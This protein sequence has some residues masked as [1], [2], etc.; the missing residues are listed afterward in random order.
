MGLSIHT[1]PIDWTSG[2]VPADWLTGRNSYR[3]SMFTEKIN[4]IVND[5]EHFFD[6]QDFVIRTSQ[7]IAQPHQ[8]LINTNNG[9]RFAHVFPTNQSWELYFPTAQKIIQRRATR[10]LEYMNNAKKILVVWASRISGSR[11][12]FFTPITDQEIKDAVKKMSKKFPNADI[13]F[14]FFEHD[15]TKQQFEYDKREIC[16]GAYRIFSNHFILTDDYVY[17]HP[18]SKNCIPFVMCEMLDNISTKETA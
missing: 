11:N 13:D 9:I 18:S 3:D 10:M 8:D 16:T 15:G 2:D 17:A 6:F 14:V 12:M 4:A 1:T 5:F 7:T